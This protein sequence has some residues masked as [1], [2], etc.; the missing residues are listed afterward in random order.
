MYFQTFKMYRKN[1]LFCVV[2]NGVRKT[3]LKKK[4]WKNDLFCVV[5]NDGRKILLKKNWYVFLLFYL[6]L[7]FSYFFYFILGGKKLEEE[8]HVLLEKQRKH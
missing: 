2:T 7:L 4:N 8:N 5:T 6:F 1:D 3:V